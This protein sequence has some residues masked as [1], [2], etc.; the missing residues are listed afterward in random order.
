[1]LDN[2]AIKAGV[3]NLMAENKKL[4]DIAHAYLV[5]KE[6]SDESKDARRMAMVYGA[7]ELIVSLYGIFQGLQAPTENTMFNL[8]NDLTLALNTNPFWGQHAGALMPLFIASVNAANDARQL[9]LEN[10]PRWKDLEAQARNLWVEM[11]PAIIFLVH[12]YAAMRVASVDIKKT[13][14]GLMYG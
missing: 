12:G 7:G 6:G 4:R 9:K 10:E 5:P 14:L 13:F 8:L 2:E 11:I 3:Q 1:M